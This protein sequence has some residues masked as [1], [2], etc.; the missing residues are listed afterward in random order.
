[1]A[2]IIGDTDTDALAGDLKAFLTA[3]MPTSLDGVTGDL[4]DWLD[5]KEE[6]LEEWLDTLMERLE[7]WV[8]SMEDKISEVQ[9]E[10]LEDW[11]DTLED[12]LE[13][14]LDTGLDA[15]D[16]LIDG[17]EEADEIRAGDGDD[18]VEANGGDD[19]VYGEDGDDDLD[20]GAGKDKMQGGAGDD[21]LTGGLGKDLMAGGLGA[22]CFDFNSL[23]ESVVGAGRDVV[24]FNG[25]EGD[26][27]DLSTIDADT[28]GGKG[29]QAFTWVGSKAFSGVDGELRFSKGIL[30]GDTNGDGKADFQILIKGAFTVD[31]IIG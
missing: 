25:L 24:R 5:E 2:L 7:V 6:M 22:D 19:A 3:S 30:E 8:E 20:G 21:D 26:E 31:D 23:K 14:F 17:T 15:L 27:I 1:M 13:T 16:D 10:A 29:N 12:D 28:D 11:L 18:D 9:M 4:E